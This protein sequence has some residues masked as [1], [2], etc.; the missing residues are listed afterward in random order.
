MLQTWEALKTWKHLGKDETEERVSKPLNISMFFYQ[1][2]IK[3]ILHAKRFM[4]F[5]Y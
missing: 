5:L 4:D 2:F 3:F 1:F